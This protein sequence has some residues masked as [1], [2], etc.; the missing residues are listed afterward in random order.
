MTEGILI[1]GAGP[2][3]IGVAQELWRR[4]VDFRIVGEPFS[5]WHRHTLDSMGLRSSV[6]ASSIDRRC[7]KPGVA[8]FLRNDGNGG[9][10]P[11]GRDLPVVDF[12]QHL[13]DVERRLPFPLLR[14]RVRWLA[15]DNGC[16]EAQTEGGQRLA[17]RRVVLATGLEGHRFVPPELRHLGRSRVIHSWE[18]DRYQ[19]LTGRRVL[20]VGGGQ[21]AAEAVDHLRWRNRVTWAV[22]R[23]PRF[24]Q[25]P[26]R[27]PTPMFN[28][29]MAFSEPIFQLPELLL[30]G[31]ARLFM[32]STVTP[33]L[34]S[35]WRAPAVG[36]IVAPTR[37]LGLGRHGEE[38]VAAAIGAGFDTVIAATGYR[39]SVGG[40]RFLSPELGRELGGPNGSPAVDSRFRSAAPGLYLVGGISEPTFGPAMRFLIGARQTAARLGVELAGG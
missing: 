19:A 29:A 28:A 11:S 30:K 14:D 12:R 2:Y 20:V 39:H 33:R 16:F 27:L 5:M 34:R 1:V 15:R 38:V 31:L 36:R 7:S 24:W 13:R 21:S 25:E 40:L 35:V 6:R 8:C 9:G 37:D 18:V 10:P 3:G 26:L 32:R 22:R 4:G 23:P 17:A